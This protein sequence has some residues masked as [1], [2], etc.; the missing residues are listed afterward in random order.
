M[1][2]HKVYW[3]S[4]AT[5]L[6]LAAIVLAAVL[7]G[8][9]GAVRRREA[10]RSPYTGEHLTQVANRLID[11]AG[12]LLLAATV[13]GIVLLFPYRLDYHRYTHASGILTSNPATTA[14][15]TGPMEGRRVST[16]SMLA[17]N[18]GVYRCDDARCADLH[19]GDQIGLWCRL[20][21]RWTSPPVRI[22]TFDTAYLRING[23]TR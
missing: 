7:I 20:N 4:L 8:L 12:L 1:P 22:C 18:A 5:A 6:V 10:T 11:T 13:G 16:V 9:L 17:L 14:H 15:V 2:T 3:P 21:W 23:E 19:A